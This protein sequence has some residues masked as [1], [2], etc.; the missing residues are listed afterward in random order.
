MS[1]NVIFNDANLILQEK[2]SN[3]ITVKVHIEIPFSSIRKV[4]IR[5]NNDS[6]IV[7]EEISLKTEGRFT[8]NKKM[9]FAFYENN[10]NVIILELKDQ[11]YWLIIFHAP[12]LEELKH[13][14]DAKVSS[15]Q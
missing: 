6:V 8:L 13:K 9:C 15:L 4:T 3:G 10:E 7:P 11:D 2:H 12:N 5:N 1:L 14:I